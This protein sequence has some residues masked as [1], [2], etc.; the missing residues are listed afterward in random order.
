MLS[1]R[2]IVIEPFVLRII[3]TEESNGSPYCPSKRSK[4][5]VSSLLS[6]VS[7]SRNV[8]LC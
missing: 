7:E 8:A 4:F 6:K 3:I 2:I 5:D 1:P